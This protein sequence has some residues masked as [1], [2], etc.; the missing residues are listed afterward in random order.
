MLNLTRIIQMSIA[1]GFLSLIGLVAGYLAL[2]DIAH[3]EADVRLEWM[4]LRVT[5]VL[6]VMFHALALVALFRAYKAVSQ[7]G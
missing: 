6:V 3:G 2:N 7:A 5:A 4:V 1:L